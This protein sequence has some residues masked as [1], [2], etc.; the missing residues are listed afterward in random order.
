MRGAAKWCSRA[1][2]AASG[3]S[4]EEEEEVVVV[5]AAEVMDEARGVVTRGQLACNSS[6]LSG[7]D[8]FG[9]FF[10]ALH[11]LCHRFLWGRRE[12]GLLPLRPSGRE[13]R[14]ETVCRI[15]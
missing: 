9:Y 6:P 8:F 11:F 12:A 1:S 13:G 4:E 10:G 15:V 5:A 14:Q 7:Y 2:G 3:D